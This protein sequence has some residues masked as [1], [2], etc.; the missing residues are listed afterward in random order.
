MKIF[1]RVFVI[2]GAL[3]LQSV[4]LTACGQ[5]GSLYLPTD[6]SSVQRGTLPETLIPFKKAPP[7]STPLETP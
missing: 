3:A 2:V 5:Q 7:R 4:S 6:E 1:I